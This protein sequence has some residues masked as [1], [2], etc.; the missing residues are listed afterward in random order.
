MKHLHLK[1]GIL[2]LILIAIAGPV[3]CAMFRMKTADEIPATVGNGRS[4]IIE[5]LTVVHVYGTPRERGEALGELLGDRAVKLRDGYLKPFVKPWNWDVSIKAALEMESLIPE[6][7]REQ[8]QGFAGKSGMSYDEVLL[9]NVFLDL[10]MSPF[11]ST[12]CAIGSASEDG[13]PIVGRNLDFPT[14]GIAEHHTI[15]VI[16]HLEYGKAIALVTWPGMIGALSGINSDG[17]T[18]FSHDSGPGETALHGMPYT[19]LY[20]HILETTTSVDAAAAMLKSA[21]RN[22]TNNVV[23]VDRTGAAVVEYTADKIA[24]RRPE[25]GFIHCTNHF[26]APPL[27]GPK[28]CRRYTALE[29][30]AA[31]GKYDYSRV[32]GALKDATF[33]GLTMQS[34]IMQPVSMKM[35][36]AFG[37]VPATEARYVELDLNALFA[38]K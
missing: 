22:V 12:T 24:V 27:G 4:E 32:K 11:C 28:R 25:N 23:L 16:E 29:N 18:L 3:C 31:E 13:K 19:L 20:R 30:A 33:P 15:L 38:T 34:M 14:Y 36:L 35:Y 7:F 6:R 9:M 37:K 21:K 5:G 1:L 26:R 2:A 8:M 10:R 17:L